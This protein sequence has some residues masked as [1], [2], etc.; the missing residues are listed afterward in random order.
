M[1]LAEAEIRA[2]AAAAEW[3]DAATR[4]ARLSV[5]VTPDGSVAVE[6]SQRLSSLDVPRGPIA[7]RV[8][9]ADPPPLPEHPAKPA[10]RTYWDAAHRLAQ[11]LGAHQAVLVGTDGLVLDGSTSTIWIAENGVLV[12]PPTPPAIP[13]VARAFMLE[14][15]PAVG[16]AIS[17]EP[18]AWER[19]D[20]AEEAFLTNAFG[21]AVA[22]RGRGGT[23]FEAVRALFDDVWGRGEVQERSR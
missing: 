20:S 2:L 12:T 23:S 4:R 16:L 10:D 11:T 5:V 19:F 8:D 17:I 15:A 13:G 9:V 21:G 7:V 22:I 14:R 18:V 6:V 3:S 1:L